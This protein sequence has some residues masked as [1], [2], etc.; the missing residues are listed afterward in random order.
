MGDRY[1]FSLQKDSKTRLLKL[2]AQYGYT[3]AYGN[4]LVGDC[5]KFIS[6]IADGKIPIGT[7]KEEVS[8]ATFEQ[9]IPTNSDE[10]TKF[11]QLSDELGSRTKVL[12]HL[13]RKELESNSY[14]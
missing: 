11:I 6:A 8:G 3:R 10:R 7:P 14:G 2:A 12:G 1:M 9:P 5:S 13:L 4:V